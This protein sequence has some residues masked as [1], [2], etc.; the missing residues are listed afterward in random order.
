[1]YKL[2]YNESLYIADQSIWDSYDSS[3][4]NSKQIKNPGKLHEEFF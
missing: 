2:F 4:W 3:K 1:M